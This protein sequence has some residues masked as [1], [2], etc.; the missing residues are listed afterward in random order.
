M[1]ADHLRRKIRALRERDLA[2]EDF[3]ASLSATLRELVPFDAAALLTSDPETS[4]PAGGVIEGFPPW[5]C[6]PFWDNE[7]LTAD[8]N[9][10][11]ALARCRD[12][13]AALSATTAGEPARS[14][15]FAQLYR[16]LGYGDECR[17]VFRVGASCWGY[18]TLARDGSAGPFTEVE[19]QAV[20]EALHE[21]APGVRAS[22]LRSPRVA[23]EHASAVVILTAEDAIES[24]SDPA[25]AWLDREPLPSVL[26]IAAALARSGPRA[27]LRVR[28]AGGRWCIVEAATLVA[29][30]GKVAV[31]IR[32]AAPGELLPILFERY[33]LTG[34]ESEIVLELARGNAT[35]QI[36]AR[37]QISTH[38]VRDHM[39]AIFE[40]VGVNSRGELIATLVA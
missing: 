1:R 25:G 24:H 27:R 17:G 37:L 36:A 39:K 11:S 33:G 34:R 23:G 21:A 20:R 10:F 35:K 31:T 4:L 16:P 5:L 29:T 2:P 9:K 3:F 26:R 15:R 22:V 14:P 13:V 32:P 12:P 40:K 28:A 6:G 18:L 7:R 38:T 8:F 30:G 19:V